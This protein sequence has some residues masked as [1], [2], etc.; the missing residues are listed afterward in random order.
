MKKRNWQSPRNS[1]RLER[2]IL[3][4]YHRATPS[5]REEGLYWYAT[6]HNDA[7]AI[8]ARHGVT[9]AQ[10]AGVI[11]CLSP[12]RTW[13]LNLQ[14]AN[15][16]ITAFVAGKRLPMVGSYGRNNVNKARSILQGIDPLHVLRASTGPKTRAFYMLILDP[17]DTHTVCVDRHAKAVCLGRVGSDADKSNV[18]RPNQYAFYARHYQTLALRLG[19]AAHQVQAICWTTW[20]RV[21]GNLNQNSLPF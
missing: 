21:H 10:A 14:D 1:P 8:A 6:A 17:S 15:D 5:D 19:L 3:A 7:A 9:V 12:G 2:N 4:C 11:A 16:L 18:V 13:G 20:R